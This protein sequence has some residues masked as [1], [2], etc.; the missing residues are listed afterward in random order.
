VTLVAIAAFMICHG[1]ASVAKYEVVSSKSLISY[2][3][4]V[5]DSEGMIVDVKRIMRVKNKEK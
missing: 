5:R 1:R 3:L 4:M 2:L